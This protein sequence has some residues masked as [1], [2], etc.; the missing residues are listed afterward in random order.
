MLD[1]YGIV[2]LSAHLEKCIRQRE[3]HLLL[4]YCS[5]QLEIKLWN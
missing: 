3:M 1:L 4:W 5:G 2:L